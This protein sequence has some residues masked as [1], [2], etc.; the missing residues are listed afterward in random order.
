M[1]KKKL[2]VI[3]NG[4]DLFHKIPSELFN[5][6]DY[7]SSNNDR[8]YEDVETY[9]PTGD[10]WASLEQSL[11]DMDVDAFEDNLGHFAPSYG[12]DGWSDS[13]HGDYQYEV[14]NCL[15]RLSSG[16]T[17]EFSDWVRGL[18]IPTRQNTPAHIQ[19]L[20]TSALFFSFNYT[21]TLNSVYGVPTDQ[22]AFIHGSAAVPDDEIIL[23]HGWNPEHH[24]PLT[25]NYELEEMDVRLA[26]GLSL[27]ESFFSTTFK[28]SAE[29]IEKHKVFF[30]QLDQIEEVYVLG[31]S[32]SSI[33]AAY[34]HTIML[35]QNF[36]EAKWV[37]ACLPEDDWFFK[38]ARLMRL[39]VPIG[40][41][42]PI[43]WDEL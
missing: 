10:D 17:A 21:S 13:G 11:A 16:L 43:L 12:G 22:I 3:G 27:I 18:P 4:F 31:H 5:F 40:N 37:I 28:N 6:R 32:L 25:A 8:V 24:Q 29:L 38:L 36:L 23:G 34:Y 15:E 7:V 20:D 35:N 14:N 41:A 30:D 1:H 26:E 19:N 33:D 39:G 2:Y 9:L 42:I